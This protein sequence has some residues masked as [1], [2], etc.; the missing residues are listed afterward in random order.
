MYLVHA[1]LESDEHTEIPAG[2]VDLLTRSATPDDQLEHVVMHT[3]GDPGPVLG[4]FILAQSLEEA[5]GVAA[6]LCQ[7]VLD[8][9]AEL[10]RFRIASCNATAPWS[11][12]ERILR[13]PSPR[14]RPDE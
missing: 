12:Y 7:R 14:R 3:H 6:S 2:T 11:Y 13:M 5:E 1:R 10:H 9:N 4:F 8:E